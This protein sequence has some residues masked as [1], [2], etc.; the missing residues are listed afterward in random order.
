MSIKVI[1]TI[2]LFSIILFCSSI[3]YRV[4][5]PIERE[6]IT[7]LP[8]IIPTSIPAKPQ[9]KEDSLIPCENKFF[10]ISAPS[11]QKYT[12]FTVASS[13]GFLNKPIT[14]T[15]VISPIDLFTSKMIVKEQGS[16]STTIKLSCTN[17]GIMGNSLPV[18]LFL[19]NVLKQNNVFQLIGSD[20]NSLISVLVLPINKNIKLG[21][22]W[23]DSPLSNAENSF[24]SQFTN[25]FS[26]NNSLTLS[27]TVLTVHRVIDIA[28]FNTKTTTNKNEIMTVIEEYKMG[29]GLLKGTVVLTTQGKDK[30]ILTLKRIE[31]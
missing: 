31:D 28:A 13:S 1:N 2:F 29:I 10:P 15:I 30:I 21:Y 9:Q 7:Q 26:I 4:I 24:L 22:V 17:K 20:I 27:S 23:K 5:R 11:E 18:S 19:Q 3:L 8:L 14:L 6:H 25:L 12:G 16:K